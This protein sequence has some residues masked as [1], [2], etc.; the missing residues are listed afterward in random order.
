MIED[1]GSSI[2]DNGIIKDSLERITDYSLLPNQHAKKNAA[3]TH[4]NGRD[5]SATLFKTIY[6]S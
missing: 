3:V 1:N 6:I 2:G 4:A 5:Y